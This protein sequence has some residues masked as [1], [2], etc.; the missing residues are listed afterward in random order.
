MEKYLAFNYHSFID[1]ITNSSTELFMSTDQKVVEF[2]R[3]ILNQHPEN[4][5]SAIKILSYEEFAKQQDFEY[6]KKEEPEYFKNNYGHLNEGDMILTIKY[7]SEDT[8]FIFEL[9]KLLNMK[10]MYD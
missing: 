7:D 4:L 8:D 9:A 3:D 6:M 5:Y 10:S 1:V 2:F